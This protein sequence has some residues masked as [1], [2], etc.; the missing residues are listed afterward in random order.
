[1]VEVDGVRCEAVVFGSL[2]GRLEEWILKQMREMDA[3]D[4]VQKRCGFVIDWCLTLPIGSTFLGGV[5]TGGEFQLPSGLHMGYM[6]YM[7][8]SIPH[9]RYHRSLNATA[10]TI[11]G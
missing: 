5:R 11:P 4:G 2:E 10:R 1:M 6:C 3:R 8:L 7:R 9:M